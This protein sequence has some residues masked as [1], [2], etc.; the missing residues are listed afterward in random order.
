VLKWAYDFFA[1]CQNRWNSGND[2]NVG[3]FVI[4]PIPHLLPLSKKNLVL[5]GIP[6]KAGVNS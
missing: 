6:A 4:S 2:K 3:G 5:D 1:K